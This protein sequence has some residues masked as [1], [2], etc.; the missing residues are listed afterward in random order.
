MRSSA[1]ASWFSNG[2]TTHVS[3][4]VFGNN[5]NQPRGGRHRRLQRLTSH[6]VTQ[7]STRRSGF[8]D[9]EAGDHQTHAY[10]DFPL[11]DKRAARMHVAAVAGQLESPK[12]RTSNPLG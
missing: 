12:A 1:S 7:L 2:A 4:A 3:M 11:V 5:Q 8:V 9:G 10:K 6:S